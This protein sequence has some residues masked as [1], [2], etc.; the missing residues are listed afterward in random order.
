MKLSYLWILLSALFLYL[1]LSAQERYLS[2]ENPDKFKRIKIRSQDELR[3]KL[4]DDKHW[5]R[6]T[7]IGFTFTH[8]VVGDN[9]HIRL[10]DIKAI[11]VPRSSMVRKGT[12]LLG[13]ALM[14]GGTSFLTLDVINRGLNQQGPL[15][16]TDVAIVT[17]TM[18]ATGWF[19]SSVF[20]RKRRK[21]GKKWQ[22]EIREL[23]FAD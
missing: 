13:G 11:S 14:L 8:V 16:Q 21:T 19:I 2:L 5:Y 17:G 12:G 20:Q 10:E 22:L 3:Y 6:D 15:I 1:P 23:D 18:I 4:N 9:D 7:I